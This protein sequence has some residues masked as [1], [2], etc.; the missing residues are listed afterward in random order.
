MLVYGVAFLGMMLG[1]L[2][3]MAHRLDVYVP[4]VHRE[5][6]GLRY[7]GGVVFVLCLV[8]YVVCSYVLTKLGQGPFVE[9]DPPRQLV[10]EGPYRWCRNPVASCILGTILGLAMM[11]S[12]TGIFCFF[13]VLT[14]LANRQ[15][16]RI[17]EPALRKRFG[18]AY[19]DYLRRVPRW[20]PRRPD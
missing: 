7:V 19:E 1:L 3:W 16:I 11:R 20:L 17:E 14:F 9:F 4:A 12:S 2:P 18:Q 6:G 5:I 13:A 8:L 15:V 10:V